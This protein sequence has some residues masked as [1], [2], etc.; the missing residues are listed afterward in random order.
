MQTSSVPFVTIVMPA[1]NEESYIA[2][3]IRSILPTDQ[4]V[5]Y[6]LLVMDG[7]STDDTR[8][9]VEELAASNPRIKLLN[10]PRRTQS[11]AMNTAAEIADP[12]ATII[13]RADC[14]AIYPAG[15]VENCVA[16]LLN[17]QSAS[18]VVSMH[19]V[20]LSPIQKAIAAAQNSRLGNGGSRHRRRAQSGY[21]EHGH[22]AAFDRQMFR[23]LGGY[24]ETAPFHEAAEF[25]TRLVRAGGRIFLDGRS[26]IAYFPR[27]NFSKLARQYF[28][29]G[30]GR[31]NT[32]LKHAS[33]PK[34]RQILPV[35]VLV[36][37]LLAIASW[38]LIGAVALLPPAAYVGA[39]LLWGIFLAVR[40]RDASLVFSGPAA[41]TMHMSWALGFLKRIAELLASDRLKTVDAASREVPQQGR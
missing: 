40:G 34:L 39:C 8:R 26:T 37:C 21:V 27:A 41:L 11:A 5:D 6:E 28:R 25:D 19:A 30:W 15:F 33:R 23:S 2:D 10:N 9:I 29:H 22:H 32:M 20:G 12:K 1:L 3:A 13:V 18:V 16:S 31:A 14:H 36:T 17:T 38:P 24:D 35:I 4:T 7:G